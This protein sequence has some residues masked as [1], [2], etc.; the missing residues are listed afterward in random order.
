MRTDGRSI[1]LV[2][3][4]AALVVTTPAGAGVYA[5]AE[6]IERYQGVSTCM[7]QALGKRWEQ[8]F[9]VS[10]AVNRWGAVE[11]VGTSIDSAPEAVRMTDLRCRRETDVAGQPRPRASVADR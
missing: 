11:A 6:M 7:D 3:W 2:L 8:R 9:G 5:P 1:G 4:T 10:M